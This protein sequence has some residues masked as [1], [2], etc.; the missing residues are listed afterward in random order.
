MFNTVGIGISIGGAG[1]YFAGG[2][3]LYFG[4]GDGSYFGEAG[5]I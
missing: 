2:G 4:A 3:G 5:P 1:P